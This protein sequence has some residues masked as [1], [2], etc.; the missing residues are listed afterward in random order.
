V[1]NPAL[2]G[3]RPLD[4]NSCLSPTCV[5]AKSIESRLRPDIEGKA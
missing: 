4:P 5:V 2:N 3:S 1:D